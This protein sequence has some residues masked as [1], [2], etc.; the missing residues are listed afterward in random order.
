M[1]FIPLMS[2]LPSLSSFLP[3]QFSWHLQFFL[4]DKLVPFLAPLSGAT[5]HSSAAHS[6]PQPKEKEKQAV[7]WSYIYR[8]WQANTLLHGSGLEM[9]QDCK[10]MWG[11]ICKMV[12]SSQ[13]TEQLSLF[14]N[15]L[16]CQ[17]VKKYTFVKWSQVGWQKIVLPAVHGNN[18]TYHKRT[19]TRKRDILFATYN[20]VCQQKGQ[21]KNCI[22]KV[23]FSPSIFCVQIN[24]AKMNFEI[25]MFWETEK[26][27]S[28][29]IERVHN[30]IPLYS[31]S[32]SKLNNS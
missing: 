1:P 16:H 4:A 24:I 7:V 26:L 6:G 14:K 29:A 21:T 11:P 17:N 10:F 20:I 12:L 5:T 2:A 32:K 30:L 3:V 8:T 22:K 25:L 15:V 9:E 23:P 13:N 28:V 31:K 18:C 19:L 27:L